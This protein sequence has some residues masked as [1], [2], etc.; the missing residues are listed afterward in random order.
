MIGISERAY[1]PK[2]T[3]KLDRPPYKNRIM[4][5]PER[6]AASVIVALGGGHVARRFFKRL[7][8]FANLIWVEFKAPGGCESL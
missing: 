3:K 5:W 4:V 2:D 8:D 6:I 1:L 7:F